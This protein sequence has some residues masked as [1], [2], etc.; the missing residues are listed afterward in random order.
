MLE[1]SEE[2][3]VGKSVGKHEVEVKSSR[4]TGLKLKAM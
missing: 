2:I 1:D 3:F 4:W